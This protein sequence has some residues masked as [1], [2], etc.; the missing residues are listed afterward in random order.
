MAGGTAPT[1]GGSVAGGCVTTAGGAVGVEM[2][3]GAAC[4]VE[5]DGVGIAAAGTAGSAAAGA[6]SAGAEVAGDGAVA[7]AALLSAGTGAAGRSAGG[8]D[9]ADTPA[10]FVLGAVA[11]SSGRALVAA[12]PATGAAGA[13]VSRASALSRAR[14]RRS[15]RLVSAAAG[16]GRGSTAAGCAQRAEPVNSRAS[17]RV[18][19][20]SCLLGLTISW[21]PE[22]RPWPV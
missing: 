10:S 22:S 21:D 14:R 13:L 19:T 6:V 3:P 1:P 8:F 11:L 7:A 17:T 16:P 2:A 15:S 5:T 18:F 9:A 4:V 12:A 20:F